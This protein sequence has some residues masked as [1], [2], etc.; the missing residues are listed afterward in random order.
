MTASPQQRPSNS[1]AI[2]RPVSGM[3]GPGKY[4]FAVNALPSRAVLRVEGYGTIKDAG[5]AS[6]EDFIW[7]GGR[8]S[9]ELSGSVEVV[10]SI[11][12]PYTVNLNNS[13][14]ETATGG[15]RI[16]TI[17]FDGPPSMIEPMLK[18][19]RIWVTLEGVEVNGDGLGD[20]ITNPAAIIA[21]YLQNDNL[22]G[23]KDEFINAAS[24]N[25]VADNLSGL[26]C[27]FAQLENID[28]L[29]WLQEIA[30]QCKCTLF[31]DQG[32]IKIRRLSNTSPGHV[33]HFDRTKI[34]ENSLTYEDS[35][36][37]E[38]TTMIVGKYRKAWDDIKGKKGSMH[39]EYDSAMQSAYGHQPLELPLWIFK[40][41]RARPG[42][43]AVLL[44]PLQA[45]LPKRQ[46]QDRARSTA[47]PAGR[48]D[49]AV[50]L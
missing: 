1:G 28:G 3:S 45:A 12:D 19:N 30:R 10:D 49:Q 37:E 11:A 14:W 31:F 20:L 40:A 36:L 39:I 46:I 7:L 9:D 21:E 24:F 23:V 32:Q 5:G 50:L 15:H 2:V 6:R 44:D 34:Y 29:S 22:M 25:S 27:A 13:T 35:P 41:V 47:T 48:L 42:C 26:V 4:I 33:R 8:T 38:L 16:T 43:F 18:D 17:T